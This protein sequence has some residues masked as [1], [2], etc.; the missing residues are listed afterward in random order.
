MTKMTTAL[1]LA[2]WQSWYGPLLEILL[3]HL[4]WVGQ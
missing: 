4:L 2:S 1:G 3:W